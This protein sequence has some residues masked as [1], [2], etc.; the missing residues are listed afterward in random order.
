LASTKITRVG[1]HLKKKGFQFLSEEGGRFNVLQIV[2]KAIP[3]LRSSV[4]KSPRPSSLF[5][6][7]LYC[8]KTGKKS[9]TVTMAHKQEQSP[10]DSLRRSW[11]CKHEQAKAPYSPYVYSQGASASPEEL[12]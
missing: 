3:E 9:V 2:R 10:V 7:V 11:A 8:G 1:C 6:G 5:V 12:A 4:A